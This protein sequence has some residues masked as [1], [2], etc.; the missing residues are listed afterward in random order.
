MAPARRVVAERLVLRVAVTGQVV[1]QG[2][3]R[4]QEVDGLVGVVGEHG[5]GHPEHDGGVRHSPVRESP[6]ARSA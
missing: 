6:G 5:V 4:Q 3:P 2:P 1:E